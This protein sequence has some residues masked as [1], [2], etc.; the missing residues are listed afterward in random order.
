V[1]ENDIPVTVSNVVVNGDTVACGAGGDTDAGGDQDTGGDADAGDI[2]G[3]DADAG[4]INLAAVWLPFGDAMLDESTFTFPSYAQSWA[5]FANDNTS[6]YPFSFAEEGVINFTASS[7]Q[8]VKVKFVFEYNPYPDVNPT[9]ESSTVTVNGAC[10]AYQATIPAQAAVNTYSSLLMFVIENDIPV[11]VS[12]VVVNGPTIACDADTGDDT[13]A[14][15][16]EV[17]DPLVT[18]INFTATSTPVGMEFIA[19]DCDLSIDGTTV[20]DTPTSVEGTQAVYVSNNEINDAGQMVIAVSM[21]TSSA[22]ATGAGFFIHYDSSELT[23][24]V[25][26]TVVNAYGALVIG[27]VYLEDSDNVDTDDETDSVVNVGWVSFA[28]NWPGQSSVELLT[29]TFDGDFSMP[30]APPAIEYQ[31][32]SVDG[33]PVAQL[34]KS[35]TVDVNYDVTDNNS[36]LT[37]LGLKVHYDSSV[38]T[39][40]EF[41]NVLEKDSIFADGP[42]NDDDNL[43]DNASTD[44]YVLSAWASITG[45]WPG[46]LPENLLSITF[47]VTQDT[48]LETTTIGFSSSDTTVGYLF[49]AENYDMD[50][51]RSTWDFDGNGHA[52]AL[53][54]GMLMMRYCFGFRGESLIEDATSPESTLNHQEVEQKILDAIYIA[55]I[56]DD[57]EVKALTDSLIL[58]RYLFGFYGYD[59]ID[60]A[61]APDASRTSH[62]AIEEHLLKHMPQ[63]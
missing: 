47:D 13:G 34:G 43:D 15:P 21:D 45:D 16:V 28:G 58:I 50:L 38:L 18:P 32:V 4:D 53:T 29:L 3:G 52:D 6:L 44:K 51:I 23:L 49:S 20:C 42:Y 39:F 8:P 26:E 56:D 40:N 17:N 12:N 55:D 48:D 41:A 22:A 63:M 33:E 37:G 61:I 19:V 31:T 46:I 2:G 5:G 30:P 57:G 54:D 27:P 24:V 35:V 59:L 14:E 36:S 25:D 1:I 9:F 7:D 62:S 10:Q 11:T 60:Q